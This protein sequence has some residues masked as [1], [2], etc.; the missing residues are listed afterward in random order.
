MSKKTYDV[1]Q[2][3][4]ELGRIVPSSRGKFLIYTADA[5]G[6]PYPAESFDDAVHGI[7]EIMGRGR[8]KVTLIEVKPLTR[9]QAIRGLQFH[10]PLL[11]TK[12]KR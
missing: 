7:I 6:G 3:N 12:R 10:R 4:R 5:S 11:L 2:G 8:A 1:F 9:A